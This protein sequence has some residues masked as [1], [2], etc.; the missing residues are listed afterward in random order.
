MGTL[1]NS[2]LLLALT[3]LADFVIT[4][5]HSYQEWNG[6]GLLWR[7]FGAIVGLDV[8]NTLGFLFFTVFLTLALFAI[9]FVGIVGP[10]GPSWTARSFDRSAIVGH[11][12]ITRFAVPPI[13]SWAST[14]PQPV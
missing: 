10:L 11:T 4:S 5:L 1:L 12:R 14:N 13:P 7:N 9:G 3:L 2:A 6:V 8:L